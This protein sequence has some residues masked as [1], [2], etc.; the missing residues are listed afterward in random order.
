MKQSVLLL[1]VLALAATMA[2]AA[3][4]APDDASAALT[5]FHA[6]AMAAWE[7]LDGYLANTVI[8]ERVKGKLREPEKIR[9]LYLKSPVR[10]Y[11]LWQ[12]GGS[13]AG[14]QI[15]FTPAKDGAN[16]FRALEGGMAGLAGP[17]R[18]ALDSYLIEKFYPHHYLVN[19]YNEGHLL[20]ESSVQMRKAGLVGKNHV[21]DAGVAADAIPGRRLHMFDIEMSDNPAD[22]MKFRRSI[23][24]YDEPTGLLLFIE[25][26]DFKNQLAESYKFMTI[27]VNP[28]ATDADF[29]LKRL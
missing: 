16:Y 27:T 25:N 12:P 2:A 29:E 24:G 14:L 4:S 3:E 7:K 8:Q 1:F 18:V 22:G 11:C 20:Q 21:T 19:Q 9:S 10:M 6:K 13:Y 15:A 26:Y 28:T 17:L 23:F 5:D